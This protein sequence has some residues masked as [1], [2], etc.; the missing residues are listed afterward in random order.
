MGRRPARG[1]AFS[2]AL[3]PRL[4]RGFSAGSPAA[5]CGPANGPRLRLPAR[6]VFTRGAHATVL[7]RGP[8]RRSFLGRAAER[9]LL[10]S[11]SATSAVESWP[12]LGLGGI[13]KSMLGTRIAHDLAPTFERSS[14]AACERTAPDATGSPTCS[15]SS[16]RPSPGHRGAR[17]SRFGVCS[18][19]QRGARPAG[20]GQLRDGPRARRRRRRVPTGLRAV[21]AT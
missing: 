7:G 3:R 8:R 6:T 9:D 1:A 14:G 4:V 20:P 16:R 2:D 11:G 19:S 10:R 18:S 13:G 21:T 12:V 5:C 15:G 17:P